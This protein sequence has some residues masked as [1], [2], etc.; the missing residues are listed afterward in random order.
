[1][2]ADCARPKR[3]PGIGDANQI[4]WPKMPSDLGFSVVASTGF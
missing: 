2:L 4:R 1:M 3:G